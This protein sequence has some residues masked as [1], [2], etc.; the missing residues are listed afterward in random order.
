MFLLSAAVIFFKLLCFP[1]DIYNSQNDACKQTIDIPWIRI[2]SQ[3]LL[4]LHDMHYC[5]K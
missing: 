1:A 4:D 5:F 2:A 3:K